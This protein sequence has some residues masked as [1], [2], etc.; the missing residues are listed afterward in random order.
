M[1]KNV[2][3]LLIPIFFHKKSLNVKI[4]NQSITSKAMQY[5]HHMQLSAFL[6]ELS[7]FFLLLYFNCI[8]VRGLTTA[9]F[10]LS[11][12]GCLPHRL[13]QCTTPGKG[14]V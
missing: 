12:L 5:W 10:F 6:L 1:H 14:L 4:R 11:P 7:N 9:P 13:A 2:N 3:E 8:S